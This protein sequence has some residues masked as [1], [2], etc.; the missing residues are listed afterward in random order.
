MNKEIKEILDRKQRSIEHNKAMGLTSIKLQDDEKLLDYITNLQ[1]EIKETN[2]NATWWQNRYNGQKQINKEHR[3][4]NGELRNG[5]CEIKEKCNKGEC[6]CTN[7]EYESMAQA[8]MKLRL[9]L[10]DYKSRIDKAIEYINEYQEV[11]KEHNGDWINY[12]DGFKPYLLNILQ[13]SDE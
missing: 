9:L 5:Y 13:G 10:D 11:L 8:N 3:K 7:E 2:D 6:D 12:K 4:L 1:E